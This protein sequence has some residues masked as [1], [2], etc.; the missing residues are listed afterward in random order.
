MV[1]SCVNLDDVFILII[2][3]NATIKQQQRGNTNV[4]EESESE[5]FNKLYRLII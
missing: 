5:I 1:L 4:L 2:F 3:R